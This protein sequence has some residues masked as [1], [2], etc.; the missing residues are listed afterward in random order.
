VKKGKKR[1]KRK[2]GAA[3]RAGIRYK[4]EIQ[5]LLKQKLQRFKELKEQTSHYN[6]SVLEKYTLSLVEQ[7]DLEY[8]WEL[9]L[10][11]IVEY[12]DATP[13]A[14]RN[15]DIVT[16]NSKPI[17]DL[18]IDAEITEDYFRASFDLANALGLSLIT[19]DENGNIN[20]EIINY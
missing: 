4:E 14:L 8:E 1:K 12:E 16:F 18:V 17:S 11:I 19:I 20:G 7:D 9:G 3:S 5:R 2:R 15:L 6:E 13:E 10:Q